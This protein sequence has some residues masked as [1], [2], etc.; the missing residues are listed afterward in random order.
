MAQTEI[1]VRPLVSDTP[2]SKSRFV[3]AQQC[4]L[5]LWF[6]VRT[7]AP[8]AQVD[9]ATQ[10]RFDVGNEVGEL[11]RQLWDSREI[12]AGRAPGV[13]V[14]DDP[15]EFRAGLEQTAAALASGARVIHEASLSHGGVKVRIDVLE[16]LEDGSF[17]LNEVKS[18]CS[19]KPEKHADDV[20]IQL[21]VA[22]GAGLDVSEVRLVHLNKR[23]VWEGGPYDLERLFV[24]HD[25]TSDAEALQ[26]M[27]SS[28]VPELLCIVNADSAPESPSHVNCVKPYECPYVGLCSAPTESA[29]GRSVGADTGSLVRR[30]DAQGCAQWV[31]QL[32]YPVFHLDFETV[33]TAL[34]LV[35]GTR[36]YQQA[37][38][39]YSLH[40]EQQDG[41]VEHRE[42]LADPSSSDPRRELAERMIADLGDEGTILQWSSFET[43]RIRDIANDPRHA[44]QAQALRA[45]MMR[46]RDLAEPIRRYV[47]DPAFEGSWSIKAVH[48]V[49]VNG[50]NSG[51]GGT[52]PAG[53][54]DLDGVTDGREASS[55]LAEYL[56]PGT[57]LE[58]RDQVAQLLLRYCELDT[59]AMVDVL[60][61]VR[62]FAG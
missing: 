58:R 61:A 1:Q 19:Y 41:S 29:G 59:R 7:D 42:F 46:I 5:R 55:A 39:Q 53:Y 47:D 31:K 34:P 3:G 15:R 37:P 17:A 28:R 50:A 38:V 48:P 10:A 14:T 22:R 8:R 33:F 9:A 13:R 2:L 30:V 36:P 60:C 51:G 32:E 24:A 27:I 12:A 56:A 23:Y 45:I 40:I 25:V 20:G 62:S 52:S 26:Q 16:R 43:S 18:T 11:A 21:W 6:E 4:P 49:L 57:T 54:G 44:D 35:I